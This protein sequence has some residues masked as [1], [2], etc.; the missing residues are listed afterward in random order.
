MSSLP[1]F[2]ASS[3]K[4]NPFGSDL[5]TPPPT[6]TDFTR[7]PAEMATSYLPT[8]GLSRA[9][10][11]THQY[12]SFNSFPNYNF[13]GSWT[14]N[15]EHGFIH[16]GACS[17]C[18]AYAEHVTMARKKEE[19]SLVE[20]SRIRRENQDLFF[21]D[22]YRFGLSKM[23]DENESL[24]REL[25]RIR[26]SRSTVEDNYMRLQ[27]FLVDRSNPVGPSAQV[28]PAL[29]DSTGSRS[30]SSSSISSL[31][32]YYMQGVNF[33]SPMPSAVKPEPLDKS[34]I[35]NIPQQRV[36]TYASVASQN[37][38]SN[39]RIPVSSGPSV[40]PYPAPLPGPA[41]TPQ[42]RRDKQGRPRY[43][44]TIHELRDLMSIAGESTTDGAAAL[45]IIKK[46]N[47]FL[48]NWRNP[49]AVANTSVSPA[50]VK[51]NPRID[52]PVDVWFV[53]LCH[54][55]HSWP[56]GVRK[57]SKGRPV[58]TDLVANRAVARMRPIESASLRNDFIAEVTDMFASPG[59]YK[60]LLE[61]HSLT[62]APE[63]TYNVF[64]GPVT[65]ES[66]VQHFA[67]S[68]F[69]PAHAATNFEPWAKHYKEC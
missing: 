15:E 27:S 9:A 17:V 55:P 41:P 22:G 19:N 62:V 37:F 58:M 46:I 5:E 29:T 47:T 66:I 59:M 52:D 38:P 40:H 2:S 35:D 33:T 42:L 34:E 3:F 36:A 12:A 16:T 31:A 57:D 63:V 67:R 26:R 14:F 25:E 10:P 50:D 30:P 7:P 60:Q 24:R 39:S 54:H 65:V 44:K 6:T 23:M 53:Y 43:P 13:P 20:A 61:K 11:A 69:T 28:L 68:G 8:A 51:P 56:K 32:D 64:S 48:I 45:S 49:Y 18:T 4:F 1:P 21:L